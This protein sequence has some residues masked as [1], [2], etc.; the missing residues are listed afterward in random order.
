MVKFC[1][2]LFFSLICYMAFSQEGQVTKTVELSK[3]S[4]SVAEILSEIH[5]QT[6]ID[7]SYTSELNTDRIIKLPVKKGD[8]N[9]FLDKIIDHKAFRIKKSNNKIYLIAIPL[10]ERKYTINGFITDAE[11]GEVLINATI[12]NLQNFTGTVSN[13]FGFYSFG[14]KNNSHQLQYS[15]VGY[16]SVVLDVELDKDTTV[17]I[18]LSP[19]TIL[20]EVKVTADNQ[21]NNINHLFVSTASFQANQLSQHGVFGEKDLFRNL[22]QLPGIQSPQDGLGGL[23]V[24]NGSPDQNLILLDDVPVYYTSH[25]LG[26]YSVFNPDAIN[27]VKLVKG[28]FPA[29]YGGRIS[30]VLDIRMK[31][32]NTQKIGGDYSIGLLTAKFNLH[33]PI[34]KNKTTFNISMRRSYLDVILNGILELADSKYKASYYFGDLNWKIVH[35]FSNRDK[36]YFSSYW[37]GDLAKVKTTDELSEQFA[38][39]STNKIGWGNFTNS[40]RWNHIYNK[41]LFGN[42][43]LILS[44]YTFL[45]K[46]RMLEKEGDNDYQEKYNY[47]FK[48]GIRDFSFKT[49]FDFIPDY[50]HYMKFGLEA[51]LHHTKPGSERMKNSG[52]KKENIASDQSIKSQEVNLFGECQIRFGKKFLVNMG[53]RWSSFIVEKTYYSTIE[54]R[55]NTQYFITPKWSLTG[56]FSQMT[57]YLHMVKTSSL[58]LP[59]D[60]WLPVTKKIKPTD[61]FQY[62]GGTHYSFSKS[63]KFSLEFYHK[64]SRNILEFK[65]EA[66]LQDIRSNWENM[67]E[68]GKGWSKGMEVGLRKTQGNT[69]GS[70]AYTLARARV[71][72]QKLNQGKSYPSPYDRRHSFSIQL[73]QKISKKVNCSAYWTYGTGLPATVSTS[74]VPSISPYDKSTSFTPVFPNRNEYRMP[75]Y[76]RLDFSINFVKE[77]KRGIRTWNISVYNLYNRKNISYAYLSQDNSYTPSYTLKKISLFSFLPSIS[78]S[79]KF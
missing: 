60:L 48:S 78:Y 36:L 43:S 12:A 2:T 55:L 20:E 61:A 15:F 57:Q 35:R 30:S 73:N 75:D 67:V 79:Y 41:H 56:S 11:T 4:L 64:L 72:Y 28:G 58:S 37:G 27:Q 77:K 70:I 33:G 3:D 66:Y 26:L 29:H 8:I 13:N 65:E 47:Q 10:H 32:G 39:K 14:L 19:I 1:F 51:S 23:I 52:N 53:T 45:A 42:T 69:S 24:R 44:R 40:L 31:D 7:F 50:K 34:K 49:E 59:T 17:N 18:A 9:F 46:D 76:H 54:P 68:V 25:L 74:M 21:A 63:L 5:K 38:E 6:G 22:N 16:K 71:R 62:T